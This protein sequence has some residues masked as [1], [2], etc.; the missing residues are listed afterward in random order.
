M[1]KKVDFSAFDR[2]T[3]KMAKEYGTIK[4][5]NGRKICTF[6]VSNRAKPLEN[7]P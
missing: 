5:R 1:M 4:K 2:I 7:K 6:F 3:S